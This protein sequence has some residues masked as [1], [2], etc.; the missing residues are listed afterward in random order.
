MIKTCLDF[1]SLSHSHENLI[2]RSEELFNS[3]LLNIYVQVCN[4]EASRV[5]SNLL[6]QKSSHR[7][8]GDKQLEEKLRRRRE[9]L[10]KLGM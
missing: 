2:F 10:T 4:T 6:L 9:G 3:Y 1:F 5:Y 7:A 8:T